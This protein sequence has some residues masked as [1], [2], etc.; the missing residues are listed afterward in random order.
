MSDPIKFTVDKTKLKTI[1]PNETKASEN[2]NGSNGVL[3]EKHHYMNFFINL[4]EDTKHYQLHIL[5]YE[6][7]EEI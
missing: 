7:K 2:L 4:I 6:F 3:K 5:T 1:K